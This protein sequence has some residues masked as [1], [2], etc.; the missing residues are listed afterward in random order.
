MTLS[1]NTKL[2]PYEIVLWTNYDV[3]PDGNAFLMIERTTEPPRQ[4]NVML[5]WIEELK[6]LVAREQ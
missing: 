5:N 3:S 2:R 4:I 6:R 1:P